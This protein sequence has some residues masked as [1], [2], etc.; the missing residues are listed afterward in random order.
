M[1]DEMDG[2]EAIV[3]GEDVGDNL[4]C[5]SRCRRLAMLESIDVSD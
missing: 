3:V 5:S 1:L 2:D 4:G